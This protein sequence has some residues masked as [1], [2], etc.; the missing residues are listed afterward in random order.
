MDPDVEDVDE[1]TSETGAQD[2]EEGK[3]IVAYFRIDE[4]SGDALNDI[5]DS[6]FLISFASKQNQ[7]PWS[8]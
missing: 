7:E 4:G 8:S 3:S 1:I 6:K 5:S 2:I